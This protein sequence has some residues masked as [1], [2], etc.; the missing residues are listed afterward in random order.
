MHIERVFYENIRGWSSRFRVLQKWVSE[1]S[2]EK[3]MFEGNIVHRE[4]EKS[5]VSFSELTDLSESPV[6][7]SYEA[8]REV[9]SR[10][11]YPTA[12]YASHWRA[13]LLRSYTHLENH[14]WLMP[15]ARKKVLRPRE[16][17]LSG[18]DDSGFSAFRRRILSSF[19]KYGEMTLVTLDPAKEP[20]NRSID[21]LRAALTN[22]NRSSRSPRESCLPRSSISLEKLSSKRVYRHYKAHATHTSAVFSRGW[23]SYRVFDFSCY[24]SW[25]KVVYRSF[26]TRSVLRGSSMTLDFLFEPFEPYFI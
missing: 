13:R 25:R 17:Q 5:C 2:N 8:R 14:R 19:V 20:R 7:H 10:N 24:I 22:A 3:N 12:A 1:S 15:L 9:Q 11:G 16:S 6:T 18:G 23:H 21:L 26:N 4:D